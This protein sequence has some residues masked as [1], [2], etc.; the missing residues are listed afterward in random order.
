MERKQ[1]P[2]SCTEQKH[3]SLDVD[4]NANERSQ[5]SNASYRVVHSDG[6]AEEHQPHA[7]T[8]DPANDF[9][10]PDPQ[11]SHTFSDG[12]VYSGHFQNGLKHGPGQLIFPNK[13]VYEGTFQAGK[14]HGRGTLVFA[15][16]T[17]YEG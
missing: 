15:D 6:S 3:T 17:Q 1:K 11:T 10:S 2:Q 8:Q 14:R 16:G 7:S 13:D 4:Q 9:Q 12:S 5:D